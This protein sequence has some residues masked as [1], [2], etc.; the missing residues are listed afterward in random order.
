LKPLL[1]TSRHIAEKKK[2]MRRWK[3]RQR[4]GCIFGIPLFGLCIYVPVPH[5][6]ARCYDFKNI[7]AEKIGENLAFF[8][9]TTPSFCKKLIITLFFEKTPIFRYLRTYVYRQALLCMYRVCKKTF[10]IFKTQSEVDAIN[11]LGQSKLY[12]IKSDGFLL[13]MSHANWSNWSCWWK[14]QGVRMYV[15][16][17]VCMYVG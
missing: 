11:L 8:A 15:C 4:N 7:F 5:K 16:I 6:Y 10:K 17:Y 13:K 9:G 3:N 1:V 2:R 12:L 14:A